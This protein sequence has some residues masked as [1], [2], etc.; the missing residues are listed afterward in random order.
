MVAAL[1][2]AKPAKR[3]AMVV[4][5][6]DGTEAIVYQHGDERF[7]WTTNEAGEWIA[8][9]ANGKWQVVSELSE[10]QIQARREAS[11]FTIAEQT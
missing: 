2:W 9:D 7:H 3:G 5:Q 10:E 8:Q 6:E 4:T 11:K 1:S